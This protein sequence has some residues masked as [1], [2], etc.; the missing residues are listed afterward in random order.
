ME[1]IEAIIKR[2]KLEEVKDSLRFFGARRVVSQESLP[3]FPRLPG[4]P[5]A[6]LTSFS[7][8]V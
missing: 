7:N 5:F 1:R 8:K 4:D 2:F 6:R 3:T